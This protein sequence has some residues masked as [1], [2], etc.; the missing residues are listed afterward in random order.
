MLIRTVSLYLNTLR[1]TKPKQIWF[2][3][4]FLIRGIFRKITRFKY[5]T[6]V[7]KESSQLTMLP[8]IFIPRK[9]LNY[10]TNN[11][12]LYPIDFAFLNK[13]KCFDKIDWNFSEHG[14]LWQY[15]LNYF[16]FLNQNDVGFDYGK[17][18]M[19]DFCQNINRIRNG[20]EP[21]PT[22]LRIIN[23]IKFFS[24]YRNNNRELSNALYRQV[25]MLYDNLEY[26]LMGNHLLENGFAL[27]FAAYFFQDVKFYKKAKE[28]IVS[29]LKEQ[30]L[31][32]G[33]HFELSPMYHQIILFRLLDAINLVKQNGF[34]NHELLD[35]LIEKASRMLNW[36]NIISFEDGSIPLL[37]D[38]ANGIA[39][40]TSEL[41]EYAIALGVTSRTSHLTIPL[42]ESGYRK[43]KTEHY[44]AIIDVGNIGP[45]Y[46]PGHAHAD[47]LSFE[48]LVDG[49]PFIVDT[50]TST[51]EDN[52]MRYWQRST[53]A[54]NTVTINEQNSSEVWK[55]H[56]VARRAKIIKLEENKGVI[57]A[58][59]DGYKNIGAVH[60]RKFEF[61]NNSI[62]IQ[63]KIDSD[64][65]GYYCHAYLHFSPGI[66]P[67]IN[68]S[69]IKIGKNSV[70]FDGADAIW[71]EDYEYAPEF[72]RLIPAKMVIAAFKKTLR[73]SIHI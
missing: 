16:D 64:N 26:H 27:L 43:V 17:M 66:E 45:D 10:P 47:T 70:R 41:N 5:F 22:S 13:T 46:I 21:Y 68:N 72:N 38:S 73:T 12:S 15:N 4:F 58:S 19:E 3:L 25:L 20:H 39:P 31:A 54:H 44:E 50:G 1:Y 32:D 59:H 69:I 9:S 48:L 29:E 60:T 35:I 23:W 2:R 11:K 61:T 36:L 67:I 34:M 28:I 56:R 57:E 24:R 37:N 63:D 62:V 7:A 52:E 14:K 30:I 40:N 42:N 55:S 53:K 8:S 18:L 6:A 65:R 71:V 33:G 51:Y 49:N